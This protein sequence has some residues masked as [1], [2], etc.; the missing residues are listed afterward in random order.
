MEKTLVIVKPDGVNRALVGDVINRFE[1]K[2][3]KLIGLKMKHLD[4]KTLDEHY[5]HHAEKPFFA[6]LKDF[7]RKAPAVLMVLEG[8]DAIEVV[9]KLAGETKGTEALPGTIRGD[10][11][12]ST[13]SN[14]VHAS[15]GPETAEKE[16]KR[17]FKKEELYDYTKIDSEIIYAPDERK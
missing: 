6:G 7:M 15:D 11:S 3:L 1:R 14:I 12:L 9:R 4:E 13:Q 5:A 10:F 17:F 16:I 2:G 8:Q